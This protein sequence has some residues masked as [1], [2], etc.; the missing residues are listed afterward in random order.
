V[1]EGA[2]MI[3]ALLQ[4]LPGLTCLVTSR[5]RLNLHGEREF[6]VPPLPVPAE[7]GGLSAEGSERPNPAHEGGIWALSPPLSALSQ[8]PSVQLFVDRAQ[9]VRPDF[10]VTER[11][12]AAVAEICGRLEGLPLALELAAARAQV[13]TPARMLAELDQRFDFLVT[14]QRGVADRHRTLR[15]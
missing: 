1:D 13:L 9:A 2:P 3:Q 6:P 14:R 12:A 7:S 10:Q 4:R 8:C 15:A 5:Q 11:N